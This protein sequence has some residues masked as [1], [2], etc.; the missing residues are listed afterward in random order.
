MG[1][2]DDKKIE[3]VTKYIIE[4]RLARKLIVKFLS[5]YFPN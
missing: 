2:T 1:F 3:D 4:T 5:Q